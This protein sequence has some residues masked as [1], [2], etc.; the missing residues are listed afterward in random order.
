MKKEKQTK[1][2]KK[3]LYLD[4]RTNSTFIFP[5]INNLLGPK[6]YDIIYQHLNHTKQLL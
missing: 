6:R 1:Q 2:T 5:Q 3:P 4:I